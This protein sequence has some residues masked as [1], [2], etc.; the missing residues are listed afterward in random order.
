MRIMITGGARSGKSSFAEQY[1][2]ALGQE[3]VYVATS[4]LYDEEMRE[5]AALHREQREASGFRWTTVEEPYD[6]AGVLSR[7]SRP[8]AEPLA[9]SADGHAPANPPSRPMSPISQPGGPDEDRASRPPVILV[10][11]L[12]LW[13]SNQMLKAGA[14]E[15]GWEDAVRQETE[16]LLDALSACRGTVLL[17]TNEVG[18]GIVP[19]YPLGRRF[20]DEAG[21]LNRQVA[22]RCDQVF[23]VTAGIPVELKSL[24]FR[25]PGPD[26]PT[27]R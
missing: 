12:T 22:E 10:D 6:L 9:T 27:A 8:E 11:C 1:A 4:Q 19:V 3:G 20:R 2:A 16:G 23:L 21:R 5:R 24:A 18:G 15:P 26:G 17:V 14:P 7:W 13:L 25:L